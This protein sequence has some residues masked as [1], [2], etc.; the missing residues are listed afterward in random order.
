MP[1]THSQVCA[2]HLLYE[3]TIERTVEN[4]CLA[5][6][7]PLG[8][9]QV[10]GDASVCEHFCH[11]ILVYHIE[12][13]KTKISKV[14][15]VA[16]SLISSHY[17]RTFWEMCLQCWGDH[18]FP[19]PCPSAKAA[20]RPRGP[21]RT[22]SGHIATALRYAVQLYAQPEQT[23]EHSLKKAHSIW[24]AF[25]VVTIP[26]RAAKSTTVYVAFS[27]EYI[28]SSYVD[29]PSWPSLTVPP[30]SRASALQ[31]LA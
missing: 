2:Q 14:R 8:T 7:S 26:K 27:N 25:T 5:K 24:E 16:C 22:W 3:G 20:T 18:D 30:T 1:C 12:Q 9:D 6:L 4:V 28:T 11:A 29:L 13:N 10:P 15:A 17:R 31:G 21:F 19:P 23:W